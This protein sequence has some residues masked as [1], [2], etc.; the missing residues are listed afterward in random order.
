MNNELEKAYD[1]YGKDGNITVEQTVTDYAVLMKDVLI[2]MQDSVEMLEATVIQ[3]P[4]LINLIKT[5][6]DYL[7]YLE[8]NRRVI[9]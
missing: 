1:E 5:A 8:D 7:F 9:L 6:N 2:K 4:H 3:V